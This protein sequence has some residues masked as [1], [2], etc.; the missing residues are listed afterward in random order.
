MV[1]GSRGIP[2]GGSSEANHQA[3]GNT[4]TSIFFRRSKLWLENLAFYPLVIALPLVV[5]TELIIRTSQGGLPNE[6]HPI[7]TPQCD[8]APVLVVMH[9]VVTVTR[10]RTPA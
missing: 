5:L 10:R 7:K 2:G 1:H 3:A 6:S 8:N 9:L 4:R